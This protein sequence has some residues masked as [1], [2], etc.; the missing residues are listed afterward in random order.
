MVYSPAGTLNFS[1][2]AIFSNGRNKYLSTIS[3]TDVGPSKMAISNHPPKEWEL[4]INNGSELE[5]LCPSYKYDLS[6]TMLLSFEI[7]K[8][9]G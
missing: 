3:A 4:F 6:F 9:K 1:V 2:D 7:R 8:R 5:L